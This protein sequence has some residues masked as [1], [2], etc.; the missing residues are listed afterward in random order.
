MTVSVI[1][2]CRM[3]F[4]P[5]HQTIRYN[6]FIFDCTQEVG[7]DGWTAGRL[8]WQTTGRTYNNLHHWTPSNHLLS[9]C[10]LTYQLRMRAFYKSV[11]E[12][13]ADL[14]ALPFRL[15]DASFFKLKTTCHLFYYYCKSLMFFVYVFLTNNK[16]LK[17]KN[18]YENYVM[19]YTFIHTHVCV[20]V[21]TYS[22]VGV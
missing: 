12:Q 18:I 1:V 10:M 13:R 8:N 2:I 11:Y 4:D 17:Q 9:N 20:S 3:S 16:T 5:H 22:N 14:V 15:F 19:L 6:V 21:C 7:K